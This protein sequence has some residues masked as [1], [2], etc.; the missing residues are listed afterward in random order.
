MTRYLLHLQD[1]IIYGPINSRRLGRSL[2]LNILPVGFKT[3]SFNCIYCQYGYTKS[4]GFTVKPD[5]GELSSVGKICD[6]LTAALGRNNE[7]DYVTFSGNGEATIHPEF[8]E[9]VEA[10]IKIVRKMAPNARTAILSNSSMVSEKNVLQALARL[11]CRFM[12]L[13]AGDE[14]TFRRFNRPCKDVKYDEVVTGLRQMDNI[15]IQAL[16]AGGDKGNF[17]PAHIE[18]WADRIGEIRPT[19]CHIYSIDRPTADG[20]LEWLS[21]DSLNEIKELTE[22]RTGIKVKV[23]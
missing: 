11:D 3:C 21:P 14:K 23:F 18:N 5:K 10:V 1:G 6:A 17:N 16:F 8:G 12:K 20:R 15:V 19:E 13:D 7:V 22:A 9:I 4:S 2:G